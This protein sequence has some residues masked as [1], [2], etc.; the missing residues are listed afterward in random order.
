LKNRYLSRLNG[1]LQITRPK[2]SIQS[3][4]YTLLGVFLG[5]NA[6]YLLSPNALRAALVVFLV[7]SF[8]FAINDYMDRVSDKVNHPE[9]PI[10]SGRISPHLASLLSAAL[11]VSA[12]SVALTLGMT[13]S[14]IVIFNIMISIIYS[15]YLKST[16]LIGNV[17]IAS[18]NASIP[19]FGGLAI[20]HLTRAIWI[21][22]LLGFL[23]TMAQEILFAIAD[24][25]GDAIVGIN[26]IATCLGRAVALRF[27]QFFALSVVAVTI[28]FWILN[29]VPNR[30]L[31]AMVP[32]AIL[33]LVGIVVVL[34]SRA[35]KRN[36]HLAIRVIKF[37]RFVSFLPGIMLR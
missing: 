30:F 22:S 9:R 21:L 8:S 10:P 5:S 12:I 28:V 19:V 36:I 2:V 37:I 4:L 29:L 32:S 24:Q 1:M 6:A 15:Y 13:L 14:I 35:T 7:V 3:G 27:F 26:T 34:D 23:F 17:V 18:L 20:G 16:L 33:P 25:E 31:Y 11:A